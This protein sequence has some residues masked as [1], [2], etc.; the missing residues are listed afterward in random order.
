MV[1]SDAG[2]E[3]GKMT[4][5]RKY[6]DAKINKSSVDGVNSLQFPTHSVSLGYNH[7]THPASYSILG[8]SLPDIT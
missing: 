8:P 2:R 4:K 7:S 1:P 3:R 5:N 6:K